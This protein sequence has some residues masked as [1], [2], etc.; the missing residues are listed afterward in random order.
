[1]SITATA[2]AAGFTFTNET[3]SAERTG[4]TAAKAAALVVV[5]EN[6]ETLIYS[7]H[8]SRNAAMKAANTMRGHAHREDM[9][10]DYRATAATARVLHVEGR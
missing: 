4:K 1:M 8:G 3:G 7:T 2:T 5:V 9:A 10:A 6:G